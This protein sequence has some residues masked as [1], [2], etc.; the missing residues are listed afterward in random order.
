[1]SCVTGFS[2]VR[3]KG[4]LLLVL[5]ARVLTSRRAIGENHPGLPVVTLFVFNAHRF[6]HVPREDQDWREC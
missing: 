2:Q 4:R 3:R 1:M 6:I 5:V